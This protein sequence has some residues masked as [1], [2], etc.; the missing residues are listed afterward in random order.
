MIYYIECPVGYFGDSAVHR[1]P[2][3]DVEATMLKHTL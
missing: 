3:L 1:V 2:H